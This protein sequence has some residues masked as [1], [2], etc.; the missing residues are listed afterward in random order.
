MEIK[1]S[2]LVPYSVQDMFD[3][4][5]RAEDYPLFL[6]WCVSS[7]I[8]E[9]GDEWVGARIDFKYLQI[10]FGFSTRNPKRRPEWL[11][12]RMV[13]GPFRHF[14]ADWLLTPLG[15]GGVHGCRINF[16]LSYEVSDG[17][18][19]RV[20]ARAVEMVARSMMDAFVKRAEDTLQ[21]ASSRP[22][23][24]PSM[25]A[26][27]PAAVPALAPGLA[28][29][30]AL[31]P[32]PALQPEPDYAPASELARAAG[33]EGD[34]VPAAKP[35]PESA[36][37]AQAP[38]ATA[39]SSA[40]DT[41]TDTTDA[42][43]RPP[44]PGVDLASGARSLETP[45]SEMPMSTVPTELLEAVRHCALS[46]ELSTEQVSV[47]AGLMQMKNFG[48]RE[49]VAP[50]DLSDNR[51]CI[52]VAGELAAIKA[53][54]SDAEETLLSLKPGDFAHE[55]GFLDG[56]KRYASLVATAPSTVLLLE[57]EALESLI[58]SHPVIL[59]RVMSAIVRTVHRIQTRLSVQASELTNY[60]VKQHG[61]Y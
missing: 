48:A 57:R 29:A 38:T 60:I 21:P 34:A 53:F 30:P 28:P 43:P 40:P 31:E 15:E 10:R 7:K 45:V 20:A 25:P 16:D 2:V 4:I 35:E 18:L 50:E 37:P 36:P 11:K 3:L 24:T 51:L 49:V 46:A 61:R 47:L 58:D 33:A 12:V 52:I 56:A 59:Y 17:L 13:E 6:P 22:L 1:R 55:L 8:L 39:P 26:A 9:R 42:E 19:D 41:D 23:L 54:G 32:A 27:V 5:E 14:H 44:E